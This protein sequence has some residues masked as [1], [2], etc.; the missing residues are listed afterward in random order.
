MVF[1]LP[2]LQ[3]AWARNT[4][5]AAVEPGIAPKCQS[6]ASP[7][8]AKNGCEPPHKGRHEHAHV[9]LPQR[10]RPVLFQ[11]ARGCAF[12]H[13]PDNGLV[14]GFRDVRTP[15]DGSV[16]VHQ[17][18]LH[19]FRQLCYEGSRDPV[20]PW[21][22]VV[23]HG[24][25]HG[26]FK[27]L[28]VVVLH[29]PPFLRHPSG[30]VGPDQPLEGPQVHRPLRVLRLLVPLDLAND[31]RGL[32]EHLLRLADAYGPQAPRSILH[33]V[34]GPPYCRPSELQ[35]RHPAPPIVLDGPAAVAPEDTRQLLDA[36]L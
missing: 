15:Q 26:V 13:Q 25:P 31:V 18:S 33:N 23:R 34:D 28:Q 20:G 11:I 36:R 16:R 6:A 29:R 1:L 27:V 3:P 4:G 32:Q 9:L 7:L 14:P 12:G 17:E 5:A 22:L 8:R 10:Y 21:S 30:D 35:I 2:T 19:Q 24:L